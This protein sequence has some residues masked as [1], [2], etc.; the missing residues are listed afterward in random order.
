M[1]FSTLFW[2]LILLAAALQ[3]FIKK[4][5]FMLFLLMDL[6]KNTSKYKKTGQDA[7]MIILNLIAFR[8]LILVGF[9]LTRDYFNEPRSE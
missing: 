9:N 3:D 6:Y 5:Y 1:L 2:Q 7:N 4:I 8:L